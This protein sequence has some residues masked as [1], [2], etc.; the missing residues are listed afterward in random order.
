MEK[1]QWKDITTP[2]D[3]C[4]F[5]DSLARGDMFRIKNSSAPEE[6]LV[7]WIKGFGMEQEQ[8]SWK[9]LAH[10]GVLAKNKESF[11]C[12]YLTDEDDGIV[13]SRPENGENKNIGTF[14]VLAR[15]L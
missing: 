13:C 11:P 5:F 14:K 9:Y 1:E 6:Y 15:T 7:L 4:A 10:H 2:K 12:V 3:A 8:L